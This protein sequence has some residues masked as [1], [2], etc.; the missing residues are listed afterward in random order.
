M[1]VDEGY[2]YIFSMMVRRKDINPN[3]K[4]KQIQIL[5]SLYFVYLNIGI[6]VLWVQMLK[7]KINQAK[8]YTN[9]NIFACVYR[10][11]N[12]GLLLGKQLS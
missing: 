7:Q 4:K 11:L 8:F 12:P 6:I 1:F 5:I 10:E 9:H 3:I 2:Y